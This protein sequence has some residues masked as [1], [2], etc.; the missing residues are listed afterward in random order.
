MPD[1]V[2]EQGV[3]LAMVRP[4]GVEQQRRKDGG[5]LLTRISVESIHDG[6]SEE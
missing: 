6:P 3:E 2:L 5:H 1:S 4:L